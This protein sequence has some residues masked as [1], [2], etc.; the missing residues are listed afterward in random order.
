M[1]AY[2]ELQKT[3]RKMV[4]GE[5]DEALVQQQELRLAEVQ[6][7]LGYCYNYGTGVERDEAEAVKWYRKAAEQ[8]YAEAQYRLG[9]CYENGVGVT[10][11]LQEAK[12]W[13]QKAAQQGET[14]S[15]LKLKELRFRFLV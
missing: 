5:I 2:E 11:S 7:W 9:E 15:E 4:R 14:L 6:Y 3:L 1:K 8:G 12:Q 10:E 13:Y